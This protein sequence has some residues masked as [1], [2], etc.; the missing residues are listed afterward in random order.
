MV[1]VWGVIW[2]ITAAGGLL[3]ALCGALYVL[4]LSGIG[5]LQHPD[6]SAIPAVFIITF[7]CVILGGSSGIVLGV[8]NGVLV[9][10]IA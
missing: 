5:M 7:F 2:R 6:L 10:A 9:A 8:V 4:I 1:V 3:G